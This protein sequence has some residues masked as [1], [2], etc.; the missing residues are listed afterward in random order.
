[1][2]LSYWY[3]ATPYSKYPRGL[4]AAYEMAAREAGRL[5]HLG[6]RVYSPIAHTHPIA[7]ASGLDPYDH[8]IWIPADRP[9][10]D[11]AHG[12]IVLRADSWKESKGIAI[13]IEEFTQAGKPVVYMSP[14]YVPVHDLEEAEHIISVTPEE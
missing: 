8:N 2:K 3:L 7:F 9:F 14:Q 12:L 6:F 5:I 4:H 1:M 11:G 13:E 10:M